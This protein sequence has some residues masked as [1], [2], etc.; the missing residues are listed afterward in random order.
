M[1]PEMDGYQLCRTIKPL[2]REPRTSNLKQ[3][4]VENG[5]DT[6]QTGDEGVLFDIDFRKDFEKLIS[7][8]S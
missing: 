4:T 2:L 1:M 5:F 6:V 7:K 3:F 8:G